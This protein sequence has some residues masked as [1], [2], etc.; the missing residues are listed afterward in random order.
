MRK[1]SSGWACP[2]CGNVYAPH[3]DECLSCN[4][5]ALMPYVPYVPPHPVYPSNPWWPY[6]APW[7][8]INPWYEITWGGDTA[9]AM[10]SLNA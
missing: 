7:G 10:K 4:G 5:A 2:K 1:K 9:A 3:V 6:T 8:P